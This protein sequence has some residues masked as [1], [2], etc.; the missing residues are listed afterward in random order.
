MNLDNQNLAQVSQELF[1]IRDYIR[2][3]YSRFNAANLYYGHGTDNAWD[4]AVYLVLSTLHLPPDLSPELLDSTLTTV[5]RRSLCELIFRRINE[6]IPSAY[7][8]KEAWFAG[9]PFY[10]DERVIIP[11]SPLAELI[12]DGF[13]PWLDDHN[14]Y[15]ILD[16]CT[17]SGCIAIACALAFPE[18]IVDAVDLSAD[19]LDVAL[20]NVKKHSLQRRVNLIESNLFEKITH[21]YDLIISNP[22]YVSTGEYEWL[23]QEYSHEPKIALKADGNGLE[24]VIQIIRESAS[25]LSHDGILVVEVG[26]TRET[27]EENYPEIPFLWLDFERGGEGAFLL[28]AEQVREYHHLFNEH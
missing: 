13:S 7:L 1:T 2:W 25:H 4:E 21:E 24:I 20:I 17:G 5:E 18:S 6:R 22:P 26:N 23:P 11:R 19:A 27:L 16:L 15:A 3:A 12:E 10:V 28:T 14:V 9:I 8:T